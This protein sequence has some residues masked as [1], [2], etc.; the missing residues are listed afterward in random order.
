MDTVRETARE[1]LDAAAATNDRRLL[2]LAGAR[3]ACYEGAREAAGAVG[4]DRAVATVSERDVVGERIGTDRTETLLGT[5]YGC[6]VLDCH[7]T[8]RP[9]AL[10]RASV[11]ISEESVRSPPDLFGVG[12]GLKGSLRVVTPL[13]V[14]LCVYGSRL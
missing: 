10:G 11:S 9:N 5:T 2:V 1:L 12:L 14:P 8:C 7:D 13:S 3:G 6:L 4:T